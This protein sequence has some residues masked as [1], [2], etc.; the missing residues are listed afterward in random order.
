MSELLT[1]LKLVALALALA[2]PAQAQQRERDARTADYI[3][4]V[5][6][7]ELVT[8]FEVAQRLENVRAEARRSGQRLPADDALRRQVVDALIEER[9]IV[10]HARDSGLR[11]DDAELDRALASIAANNQVTMAQMRERLRRDGIDFGRFRATVRDQMLIERV[12]ERE[13]QAMIRVPD[14]EVDAYL[15]QKRAGTASEVEYNIAQILVGVR[16]GASDAEVATRRARAESALARVRGGEPFDAVARQM[17]DDANREQGGEIGPKPADRL[18]DAFLEV[19]RSMASGDIAPTLLRTGAGFHVL[20]LIE[21]RDAAA[22]RITQTRARHILLRPS[23]QLPL[24]VAT[25]R[26]AE[27]KTQIDSGARR[28][29]ELAREQSQDGSAERGGDL[30]W[31]SPGVLVPEFEEAMNALPVGG[32][33]SP[34]V[35]RFG[36]HL[37]QVTERRQVTMDTKQL[38]EQARTALREQKFEQAYDDWVR[39]LR[40]RAYIEM[41]E[42]PA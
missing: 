23:A 21:R 22:Q 30:G 19:V 29:D 7:Q 25:R 24:E 27:F 41:R 37:I 14:G 1:K 15:E 16:E 17:S 9:V 32:V 18:P 33:S 39:D 36:V 11:I 28:F 4:A 34:V 2:L 35:S 12:R 3:V 42:P 5:V 13:V 8:A 38:R 31:V 26:L 10:T 6:N 40:S 20:K